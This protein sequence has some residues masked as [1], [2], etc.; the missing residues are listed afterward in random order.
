MI[1]ERNQKHFFDSSV[2][3]ERIP[4][5]NEHS[6]RLNTNRKAL[7]N[8]VANY[9]SSANPNTSTNRSFSEADVNDSM[10]GNEGNC[11]E[12]SLGMAPTELTKF[13][14]RKPQKCQ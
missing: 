13:F 6:T 10:S 8:A 3:Y 11:S 12:S 9:L 5:E 14:G 2:P 7:A 4:S 1:K